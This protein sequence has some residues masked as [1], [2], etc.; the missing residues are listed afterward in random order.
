MLFWFI[1]IQI[2]KCDKNSQVSE[3]MTYLNTFLRITPKLK[4]FRY[5]I[6]SF[7]A[8]SYDF[9]DFFSFC[10]LRWSHSQVS[11]LEELKQFNG[12]NYF[13]KII[14]GIKLNRDS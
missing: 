6:I 3:I 7:V 8:V 11:L 10:L 13:L 5:C 2:V 12:T 9:V 4:F 1:M 14:Y